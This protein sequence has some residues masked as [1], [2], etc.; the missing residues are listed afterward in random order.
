[1]SSTLLSLV[2]AALLAGQVQAPQAHTTQSNTRETALAEKLAAASVEERQAILDA[3]RDA[4]TPEL[5]RALLNRV[6]ALRRAQR[7][8]DAMGAS[9]LLAW[10]AERIDHPLG[11]AWAENGVGTVTDLR[12][13]VL[14]A[15]PHFEKAARIAEEAGAADSDRITLIAALNNA[16]KAY[17][18]LGEF[19]GGLVR[20]QDRVD[21]GDVRELLG[22]RGVDP[23]MAMAEAGDGRTA[24]AVDDLLAA[25]S[26]Q[27]DPF[28]SCR[29]HGIG[30]K[31]AV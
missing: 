29:E 30:E 24:R 28:S 2:L 1:M 4:W 31:C 11:I 20:E 23:W 19:L 6:V 8:D 10:V 3:A 22:D 21:V 5:S 9:E 25:R 26:V 15:L 12:G 27:V 17:E 14:G 13:D 16:G 18:N 7:L